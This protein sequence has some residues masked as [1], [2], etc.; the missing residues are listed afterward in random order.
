MDYLQRNRALIRE[1]RQHMRFQRG[2]V[3]GRGSHAT[4][5]AA[6]HYGSSLL[7]EVV[8]VGVKE[9]KLDGIALRLRTAREL[10]IL[11]KVEEKTPHLLPE[12]PIVY[13]LLADS[14]GRELAVFCEDFSQGGRYDIEPIL[15]SWS[16]YIS[17]EEVPKDL[18]KVKGSEIDNR[19]LATTC[20]M[21]NGKRRIGDFGEIRGIMRLQE[22]DKVFPI[23]AIWKQM[24]RYTIRLTYPF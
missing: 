19:D 10:S 5:T 14:P 20:F 18:E 16:Q 4:F 23:D 6:G 3:I 12:F 24:W 8:Y 9:I 22:A 2:E 11:R 17:D 15:Q 7:G 13:G 1:M 21:V